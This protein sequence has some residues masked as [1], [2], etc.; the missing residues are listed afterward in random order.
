MKQ[1]FVTLSLVFLIGIGC[2]YSQGDTTR[3]SNPANSSS[4]SSVPVA[5]PTANEKE[6]RVEV[7]A[8]QVP[9]MLR[10]SLENDEKYKGW[11]N[12]KIYLDKN[13]RMYMIH[14]NDGTAT[15]TY[16]FNEDGEEVEGPHDTENTSR[17]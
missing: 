10:N 11:E 2:A 1:I 5:E 13:N 12:S 17:E 16:R 8:D 4:Q 3:V 7:A 14:I 9:R 15:K 6:D